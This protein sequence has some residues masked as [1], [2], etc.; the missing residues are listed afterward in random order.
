MICFDLLTIVLSQSYDTGHEFNRLIQVDLEFFFY[1]F[2]NFTLK[3]EV[4]LK[5]SFIILFFDPLNQLD[6]FC[7]ITQNKYIKFTKKTH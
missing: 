6:R 2:S 4:D 3:Q 1:F 5:L 7:L